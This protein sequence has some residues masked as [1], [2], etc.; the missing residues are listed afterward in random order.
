[1]ELHYNGLFASDREVN[2]FL[3]AHSNAWH[4]TQTV[5]PSALAARGENR[6]S[7]SLSWSDVPSR[8]GSR[9]E[10]HSSKDNGPFSLIESVPLTISGTVVSGLERGGS[11]RFRIRTV[12][13]PGTFNANKVESTFTTVAAATTR[14]PGVPFDIGQPVLQQVW[15]DPVNG[16]DANQ[17]TSSTPFRTLDA[18]WEYARVEIVRGFEVILRPGD[19]P[20]ATLPGA[21][22][23]DEAS[24]AEPAILR[25]EQPGTARVHGRLNVITDSIY[26]IGVDLVFPDENELAISVTADGVL[27][28]DI[29]ISRSAGL[30]I[31]AERAYIE[32]V[33]VDQ[34]TIGIT[35]TVRWGHIINSRV[36]ASSDCVIVDVG[37]YLLL[38]NNQIGP[39]GSSGVRLGTFAT[40][41][42]HAEV[43][44]L[45]YDVYD[46]KVTNNVVRDTA[47]VPLNLGSAYNILVAHNTIA[48]TGTLPFLR[49]AHGIRRCDDA[50]ICQQRFA[51]G[52]WGPTGGGTQARTPSKNVFVYSNVFYRPSGPPGAVLLDIAA[53]VSGSGQNGTNIPVPTRVDENLQ[54]RGNIF[55]SPDAAL[56]AQG[57]QGCDGANPACNASQLM[58]DNSVNTVQPQLVDA[59]EGDFHPLPGGNLFGRTP[60]PIPSFTWSD[61]AAAPPVPPG[62][63]LN[64]I[65]T[66]GDGRIRS[67][68]VPGALGDPTVPEKRRAV[69]R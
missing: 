47:G 10:I 62:D 54:V 57:S 29:H 65:P 43:P 60:V 1:M 34:A 45:H 16:N 69:R 9:Y 6:S 67:A 27:L 38:N 64:A 44:W 63:V 50:T 49:A 32:Q 33:T 21:L 3:Q 41:E 18:A 11:Y 28:R 39:C 19:Y 31:Q 48:A 55:W 37:S 68:Y 5:A 23:A 56:L 35:F 14:E 42:V 20:A 13:E 51:L 52:G 30:L 40:S 61:A 58:L 59:P 25:A 12:S 24:I 66:N 4:L 15:V 46:V 17:G 2:E 36:R 26:I 8:F 7:I 53:P 22:R